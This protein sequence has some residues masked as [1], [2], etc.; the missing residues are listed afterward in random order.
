MLVDLTAPYDFAWSGHGAS[1]AF[2]IDYADLGLSVET[3]RA[4]ARRLPSS[5]LYDL[6]L[7]H[8]TRAAQDH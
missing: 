7:H 2:Q 1:L 3:V 8:L 4:A 5:P 6:V